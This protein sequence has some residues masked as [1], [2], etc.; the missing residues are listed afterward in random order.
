[1]RACICVCA[2]GG[3]RAASERAS[4]RRR[5]D[6][7]AQTCPALQRGLVLQP[8][9][10]DCR[11]L[12]NNMSSFGR[13]VRDGGRGEGGEDSQG[14]MTDTDDGDKDRSKIC[15]EQKK[16][17]SVECPPPPPRLGFCVC[18]CVSV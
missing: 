15:Q 1:M 13:R 8:A 4:E 2:W 17:R 12:A 14:R 9:S 16:I 7:I 11:Q 3:A 5:S 6:T 10:Q 18:E